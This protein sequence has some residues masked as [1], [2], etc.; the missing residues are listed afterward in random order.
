MIGI[1][2]KAASRLI[3]EGL[4]RDLDLGQRA[5]LRL[6]LLICTACSRVKTQ[7]AFLRGAAAQYPGPEEED[8]P[9]QP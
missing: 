4:D 6:H 7:L 3:S 8:R 2:C 1:D 5:A 9:T